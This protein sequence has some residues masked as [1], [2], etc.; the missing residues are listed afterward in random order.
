MGIEDTGGACFTLH[1]A[2]V[3][4]KHPGKLSL[5]GTLFVTKQS[6]PQPITTP[7]MGRDCFTL[8][9]AQVSE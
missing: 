8:H 1:Q 4:Q 5:R 2:Q 7:A 9:Q 6:P 3:S